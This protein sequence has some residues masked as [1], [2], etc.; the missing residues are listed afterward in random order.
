M[1]VVEVVKTVVSFPS[2]FALLLLPPSWGSELSE[3]NCLIT[4]TGNA[5]EAAVL[6]EL[7]VT[8]KLSS[9]LLPVVTARGC[10]SVFTAL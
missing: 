10:F 1:F 4:C 9:L 7:L 2:S 8:P 6:P 5:P 3:N